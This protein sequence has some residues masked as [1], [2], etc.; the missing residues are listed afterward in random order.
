MYEMTYP[1]SIG[2]IIVASNT[3]GNEYLNYKFY[4][5]LGYTAKRIR[6]QEVQS[7]ITYD[8]G[9][10]GPHTYTAPKHIRPVIDRHGIPVLIGSSKLV[11][12]KVK[13]TPGMSTFSVRLRPEEYYTCEGAW[14][15]APLEI[16][17]Y[18]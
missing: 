8:D 3:Y 5:V 15:E 7:L 16:Y 11:N 12:Y 17:N 6:I 18:H 9:K 10:E 2:A 4:R 1:F 14:N 13:G